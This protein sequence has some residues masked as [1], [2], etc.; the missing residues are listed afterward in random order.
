M[1][2]ECILVDT[3]GP[4]S[5]VTLN[6]PEVLNAMNWQLRFDLEK[7]LDALNEDAAVKVVILRGAGRAFCAGAY[8]KGQTEVS[9]IGFY[10]RHTYLHQLFYKFTRFRKPIIG[11]I[12]GYCLGMGLEFAL[13]CDLLIASDEAKFGEP[14]IN[15]G[16]SYGFVRL[17]RLV[18]EKR[19][20]WISLTGEMFSAA[21]AKDWGIVNKVVPRDRLEEETLALAR[22]LSKQSAS[23]MW[24][25]KEGMKASLSM[26]PQNAFV[27]ESMAEALSQTSADYRTGVSAFFAKTEPDFDAPLPGTRFENT[28][29]KP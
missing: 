21:E 10:S 20:M 26:D 4:I 28:G 15:L 29:P 12:H 6:R 11:S 14:E 1:T 8:V 7:A 22:R 13:L 23:A 9:P 19:A 2:Y 16:E 18:G 25:L 17:P 3:D 27:L 5:T 24:I